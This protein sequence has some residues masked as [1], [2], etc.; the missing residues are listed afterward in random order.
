MRQISTTCID[1]LLSTHADAD[2]V[3]KKQYPYVYSDN[4]FR[5]YECSE[6]VYTLY[7]IIFYI[8]YI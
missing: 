8:L 2:V 7:I 5:V 6:S 3:S 4:D 1:Y